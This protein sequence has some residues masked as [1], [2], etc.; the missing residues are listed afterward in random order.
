MTNNIIEVIPL[1]LLLSGF[2]IGLG[3]V[4]VIDM[5]GFLGRKSSYWSEATIRTHKVTKPLIWLGTT[6]AIIGGVLYFRNFP[7]TAIPLTLLCIAVVLIL[8]GL[9]LSFVVSP[10]LLKQEVEGK[11]KELLPE[12]WQRKV[13]FSF[14]ISDLG[15]W[16]ALFLLTYYLS[17]N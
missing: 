10:Y 6:L 4:T 17:T 5:H 16:S 11:S 13:A 8:N 7:F 12:S 2:V 1:F 3:A 9:F 14:I 15:W